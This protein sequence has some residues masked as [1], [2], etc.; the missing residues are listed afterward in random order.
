MKKLLLF[1][2]LAVVFIA[3]PVM[4][5]EGPYMGV[6][7]TYVNIV[8]GDP[9]FDTIDPA[10]GLEL[11]VGYNM[12]SIAIEGNFIGSTHPD[13]FPGYSDGD[14]SGAS[15]DLR[16]S[17][18]QEQD[19]TQ[20]YLLAGLGAYSFEQSGGGFNYEFTGTGVNLG[21]GFEHF[22]NQQ[23]AFDLR[24]VYRVI[25]YDEEIN[26]VLWATGIDG[27][28]FTMSAALNLHF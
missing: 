16:I 18:S 21:V 6:G 19:P 26:G 20:V 27:D 12:G 23:V 2:V 28:T 22:F 9:Y 13:S 24:G 3:T 10:T 11:R 17:F 25:T 7:L 1:A 8:S 14:F 5:K 4:A 15:V